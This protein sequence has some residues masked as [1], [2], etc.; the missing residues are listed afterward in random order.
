MYWSIESNRAPG[1]SKVRQQSRQARRPRFSQGGR[2]GDGDKLSGEPAAAPVRRESTG[3]T[4]C[5]GLLPPDPVLGRDQTEHLWP[6][7]TLALAVDV[8]QNDRVEGDMATRAVRPIRTRPLRRA[9][10]AHDAEQVQLLRHDGRVSGHRR[11]APGSVFCSAHDITGISPPTPS[12]GF[13]TVQI[14]S[15]SLSDCSTA[16]TARP[17]PPTPRHANR[18][19]P[20]SRTTQGAGPGRVPLDD[21]RGRVTT[22]Y[23]SPDPYGVMFG[24]ALRQARAF[25]GGGRP[26]SGPPVP[27]RRRTPAPAGPGHR[28]VRR[29]SC[30]CRARPPTRS[31]RYH[32]T[33][34]TSCRTASCQEFFRGTRVPQ[35]T[36]RLDTEMGG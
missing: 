23:T 13:H 20:R 14:S 3:H 19:R 4:A 31:A 9:P 11:Q 2:H 1:R 22:V 33:H 8:E 12:P 17:A 32:S 29:R 15:A 36:S 24:P 5:R 27:P 18:G 35:L 30:Q 28:R 10:T 34:A 21:P 16:L 25:G 7:A 6:Q 26:P